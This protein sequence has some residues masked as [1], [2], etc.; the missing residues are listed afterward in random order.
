MA[1]TE[2]VGVEGGGRAQ[3]EAIVASIERVP[4]HLNAKKETE[5]LYNDG[6]IRTFL[7]LSILLPNEVSHPFLF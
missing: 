2:K 7:H 6:R 3:T 5:V 4:I 1:L